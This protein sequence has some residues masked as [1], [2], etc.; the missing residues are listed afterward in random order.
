[1][2]EYSRHNLCDTQG[3]IYRTMTVPCSVGYALADYIYYGGRTW[4]WNHRWPP[5]GRGAGR[6]INCGLTLRELTVRINPKTGEPVRKVSRLA[7]EIALT[8]A[9]V[10]PVRFVDHT[11]A[12]R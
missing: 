8:A 4:A 1:M 2:A 3:P 10:P 5:E 12:G 9:D 7:R 11:A 6:C